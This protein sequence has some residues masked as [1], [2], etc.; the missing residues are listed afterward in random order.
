MNYLYY[1]SHDY[2][3]FKKCHCFFCFQMTCDTLMRCYQIYLQLLNDGV[4][5]RRL[6]CFFTFFVQNESSG[7]FYE[8]YSCRPIL[9]KT[10]G[11]RRNMGRESCA[12]IYKYKLSL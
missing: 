1:N 5:T 11:W 6:S 2:A 3:D 8:S 7:V 9:C 4:K 10:K 12:L